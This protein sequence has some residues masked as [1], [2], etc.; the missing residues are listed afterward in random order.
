MSHRKINVCITTCA[1]GM[2]SNSS[3]DADTAS[4][5]HHHP[6]SLRQ[7]SESSGPSDDD[8]H[9]VQR[10]HSS[11]VGG[12]AGYQQHLPLDGSHAEPSNGGVSALAWGPHGYQVRR[13]GV[14]HLA[15]VPGTPDRG[16]AARVCD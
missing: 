14:C 5:T 7:T 13:Q 1:R 9:G 3:G 11:S 6:R 16:K 8:P 10:V 12:I 4:L 2:T 15:L